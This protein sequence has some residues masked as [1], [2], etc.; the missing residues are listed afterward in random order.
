[1]GIASILT[2]AMRGVAW[3]QVANMAL[4]YGPEILKKIKDRRQPQ[5]PGEEVTVP[6]IE[7]LQGRIG[8]LEAALVKQQELI[9]EQ[10]LTIDVLEE[11]VKTLQT[12]LKIAILL[13]A[14]FGL[15]SLVLAAFLIRG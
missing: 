7:Q 6:I 1:M 3:G 10:A 11:A 4:Q 8:E 12:R 9:K 14:G 2:T 13:A 5:Q 15:L